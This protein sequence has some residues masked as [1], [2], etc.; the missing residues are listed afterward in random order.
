VKRV[1]GGVTLPVQSQNLPFQNRQIINLSAKESISQRLAAEIPEGASIF[2]GIGTTLERIAEALLNHPGLTVITNN[3]NAA[4][5]LCQSDKITTFLAGGRL[6]ASDQD[7]TGEDT[8]AFLRKFHVNYGVFG[9]GGLGED[10]TLLDFSPEE[11][12]ISRA[13]MEN[14]EKRV[15][16]A[17]H[18]KYMR[19]AP[20][21]SGSI[22]EIDRFYIDKMPE[23]LRV[24]CEVSGVQIIECEMM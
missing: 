5:I 4:L 22:S 12:N 24:L 1:H 11:S 20:V 18:H 7:T 14:C 3:L 19:S 13:I 21:R 6:R 8:T 17:D 23:N 2:L 16:V 15:L 9:V 10:G